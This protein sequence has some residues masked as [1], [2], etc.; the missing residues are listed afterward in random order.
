METPAIILSAIGGFVILFIVVLV[1]VLMLS[2]SKPTTKV[3]TRHRHAGWTEEEAAQGF[4][5]VSRDEATADSGS[6]SSKHPHLNCPECGQGNIEMIY[7]GAGK[8]PRYQCKD[9]GKVFT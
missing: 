6:P 8:Y 7:R 2:K 1:V 9:C 5:I 4:R 3:P